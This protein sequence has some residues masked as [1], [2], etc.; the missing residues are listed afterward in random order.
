MF[1]LNAIRKKVE[2]MIMMRKN[3]LLFL[4]FSFPHLKQYK[5]F[6]SLLLL[7]LLLDI[8]SEEEDDDDSMLDSPVDRFW[9]EVFRKRNARY[10]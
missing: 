1:R 5:T 8:S 10:F 3:T 6:P 4:A 9:L 7:L 2:K